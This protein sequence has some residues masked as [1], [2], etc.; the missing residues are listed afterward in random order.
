MKYF[1]KKPYGKFKRNQ[2][3]IG[4]PI[5]P[6]EIKESKGSMLIFDKVKTRELINS[7]II[8]QKKIIYKPK[9]K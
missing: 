8:G 9:T 6:N 7:K 1:F 5:E 4:Y 3:C 2:L